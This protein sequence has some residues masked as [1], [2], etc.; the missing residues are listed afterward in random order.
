MIQV[1]RMP[2]NSAN[3]GNMHIRQCLP[4]PPLI[5][6]STRPE[7]LTEQPVHLSICPSC[8]GYKRIIRVR[9]ATYPG[10][11]GLILTTVRFVF[12]PWGRNERQRPAPPGARPLMW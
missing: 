2:V 11:S 1:F 8:A 3:L 4:D 12:I 9:D 10:V 7:A 5:R 6:H